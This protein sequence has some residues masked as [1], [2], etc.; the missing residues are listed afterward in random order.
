M[1]GDGEETER[2]GGEEEAERTVCFRN[3][4]CIFV[5]HHFS[6]IMMCMYVFFSLGLYVGFNFLVRYLFFVFRE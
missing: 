6:F 4:L 3:V 5:F 1:E 2:T